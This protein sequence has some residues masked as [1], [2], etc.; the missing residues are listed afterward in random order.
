MEGRFRNL[1]MGEFYIY[2]AERGIKDTIH[3]RD[4]RFEYMRMVEDTT[5]LMLTFPNFSQLPIFAQPGVS[6]TMKGDASHLRETQ[7]KGDDIND[8]MT[9]FRLEVNELTPPE[10]RNAAKSYVTEHPSSPIALYLVQRYFIQNEAPD[11]AKAYELVT[12]VS[13]AQPSNLLARQ[14][15]KQLEQ[16]RHYK[17]QGLLPNFHARDTKGQRVDNSLLKRD[18]NVI[19]V[20]A[21][22]NYESQSMLRT[23]RRMER[24]NP[25]RLAVVSI[26]L[27][28][29][30]DEGRRVLERDSIRWPNVCDGLM[31]QSPI[32][33][34]LS[35]TTVGANIVTD[36]KG[37]IMARNLIS[38]G[39][40]T[41]VGNMLKKQGK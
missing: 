39:L 30:P 8:E 15:L 12:A 24:D 41:E 19:I 34:Q 32:M 37:M 29:S 5:L 22:W 40:S 7:V 3:V 6:I 38:S 21:S 31:W 14:L 17:T 1:N 10:Q 33:Q 9:A 36:K 2:D 13:S 20:W 11:Y 23:L 4:G 18:V 25:S 26:C 16:L 28:A 35:L 27:D